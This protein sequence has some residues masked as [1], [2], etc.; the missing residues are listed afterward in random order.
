ML[1]T[2]AEA[3]FALV[4]HRKATWAVITVG[5]AG[6]LL[7]AWFNP[8]LS[9][10]AEGEILSVYSTR[11]CGGI[12]EFTDMNGETYEF[13]SRRAGEQG[14]VGDAIEVF[15]NPVDPTE[16][17]TSRI[18]EGLAIGGYALVLLI[19]LPATAPLVRR[20]GDWERRVRGL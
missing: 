13:Y 2:V 8:V 5:V 3:V 17:D 18:T 1:G 19:L 4:K 12:A 20:M 15:Y 14:E 11:C 7:W 10:T 9:A 16:A 6:S